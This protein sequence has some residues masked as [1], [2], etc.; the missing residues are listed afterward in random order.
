MSCSLYLKLHSAIFVKFISIKENPF[1]DIDDLLTIPESAQAHIRLIDFHAEFTSEKRGFGWHVDGR[2][3][4]VWGTHTHIPTADAQVLP[5]GTGYISDV[6]MCGAY[7]SV[8][9]ME[10]SGPLNMFKTQMKPKFSPPDEGVAEIGAVLFDIEPK[11]GKTTRVEHI[12][13]IVE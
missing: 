13:R 4:G 10:K 12:R 6:G 7:D 1:T 5:E 11:D 3:S 8:I 2:V 9:G